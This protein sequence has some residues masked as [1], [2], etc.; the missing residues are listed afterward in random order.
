MPYANKRIRKIKQRIYAR[1]AQR[2][3]REQAFLIR[4]W[5]YDSLGKKCACCSAEHG[6]EFDHQKGRKY[7]PCSMNCLARAKAYL[8]DYAEGNLRLLCRSCNG[9]DGAHRRWHAERGVEHVPV[10]SGTVSILQ[11][12]QAIRSGAG[13]VLVHAG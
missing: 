9:R 11:R 12:L 6:L 8:K 5:L 3:R 7:M 1:R 10:S 2:R 13:A 4:W